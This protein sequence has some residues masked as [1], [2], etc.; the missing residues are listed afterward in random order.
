MKKL[1]NQFSLFVFCIILYLTGNLIYNY[2]FENNPKIQKSNL[3]VVGDSHARYG[4]I[5]DSFHNAKNYCSNADNLI[6]SK[7]KLLRILP[8]K[9]IDT[10]FISLGYHSFTENYTKF[11]SSND[12]VIPK[13]LERYLFIN[14]GELFDYDLNYRNLVSILGAKIKKPYHEL[15]YLGVFVKKGEKM[16]KPD[17]GK[18]A[19]RAKTHFFGTKSITPDAIN[20]IHNI[21]RICNNY[22]VACYFIFPPTTKDYLNRIPPIVK[23]STDS[24]LT[25]LYNKGVFLPTL[26]TLPDSCFFDPDHL[27][28]SG[29]KIYTHSLMQALYNKKN[30][31]ATL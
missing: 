27:N 16:L 28:Y 26:Q 29:A 15:E 24:F 4:V 31:Q 30:H 8:T 5:P 22:N 1:L 19:W 12:A 25:V 17:T 23:N 3:I 20:Q 9:Q 18:A 6:M 21:L 10:V 13:V 11:F 2:Y 7:W 14:N